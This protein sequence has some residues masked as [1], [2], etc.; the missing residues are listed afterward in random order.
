M[1][2]IFAQRII[3]AELVLYETATRNDNQLLLR[4]SGVF[5]IK[6]TFSQMIIVTPLLI[7]NTQGCL[8]CK[9]HLKRSIFASIVKKVIKK[10][11]SIKNLLSLKEE[12]QSRRINNMNKLR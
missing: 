4:K 1:S 11:A 9:G 3:H 10:V 2:N 6:Y 12:E 5:L 8:I 7:V